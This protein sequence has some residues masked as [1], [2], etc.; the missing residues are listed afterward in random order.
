MRHK[1]IQLMTILTGLIGSIE[2]FKPELQ[3]EFR[4][5]YFRP[6]ETKFRKIY[7]EWSAQCQFEVSTPVY[8]PMPIYGWFNVGYDYTRGLSLGLKNR[9]SIRLVPMTLGLK[10]YWC[11]MPRLSV[12]L[13]AGGGGTYVQIHDDNPD[14]VRHTN[15]MAWG[16]ALKSGLNY[17]I[18]RSA[19][20][21][22]FVDYTYMHLAVHGK[23]RNNANLGGLIIGFGAGIQ[24]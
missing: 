15:K 7:Q 24:F 6:S 10:Y 9:T 18:G 4:I 20:A 16:V 23:N 19:F 13:G 12:Y 2:A 22:F 21:D 3:P 8:T 11:L 17:K 1:A 14:V 5:G